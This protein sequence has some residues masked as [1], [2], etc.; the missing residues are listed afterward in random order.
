MFR[1]ATNPV[2]LLRLLTCPIHRCF[3]ANRQTAVDFLN[4]QD[5]CYVLDGF[6]GWDPAVSKPCCACQQCMQAFSCH[7]AHHS[8]PPNNHSAAP[9]NTVAAAVI[10]AT[11]FHSRRPRNLQCKEPDSAACFPSLR[12]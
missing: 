12:P 5:R 2:L 8:R 9:I 10:L 7:S 4:M 6:A 1:W 3:L 11:T